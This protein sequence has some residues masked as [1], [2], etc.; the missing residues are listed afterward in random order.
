MLL[1][2]QQDHRTEDRWKSSDGRGV[3][4]FH[5]LK[6][7]QKAHQLTL[8]VY[9]ITATFPREELYGL[10]SQLR[11]AARP[12]RRIWRRD[13]DATGMPSSPASVASLWDQQANSNITCCWPEI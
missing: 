5:E 2:G 8:A 7:W 3:K 9:Q 1:P 12:S 11:R 13:A 10:T 6:V 4:D